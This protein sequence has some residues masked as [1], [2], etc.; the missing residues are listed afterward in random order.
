MSYFWTSRSA[1]SFGPRLPRGLNEPEGT[2]N[3]FV[4]PGTGAA[5]DDDASRIPGCC[6]SPSF[7]SSPSLAPSP[8]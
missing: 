7:S 5:D 2:S 4:P 6:L 1:C 3:C 8:A